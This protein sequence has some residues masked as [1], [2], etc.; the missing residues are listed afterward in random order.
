MK[1]AQSIKPGYAYM[2]LDDLVT[3]RDGEVLINRHWLV[4][5]DLGALFWSAQPRWG[6]R[7]Q[8]NSDVRVAQKVGERLIKLGYKVETRRIPVAYIGW[9]GHENRVHP[10]L[11]ALPDVEATEPV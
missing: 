4:I 7:P 2:K 6:Y 10:L 3:P 1:P 9:S 11:T 5:P 8:C